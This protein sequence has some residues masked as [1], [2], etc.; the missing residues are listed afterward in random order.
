MLETSFTI[1]LFL[2]SGTSD[3]PL[4]HAHGEMWKFQV[5]VV[6][7]FFNSTDSPHT[8]DPSQIIL[9]R[10][11]VTDAWLHQKLQ[12]MLLCNRGKKAWSLKGRT[13]LLDREVVKIYMFCSTESP[14]TNIYFGYTSGRN[15]ETVLFL[16]KAN[17]SFLRRRLAS[18][19]F[20][21]APWKGCGASRGWYIIL[22]GRW[23][24]QP[25]SCDVLWPSDSQSTLQK[26]NE[27]DNYDALWEYDGYKL[28]CPQG[29]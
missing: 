22:L 11:Q 13:Y 3:L 20:D 17:V 7:F 26:F 25:A 2:C 6:V 1:Y 16:L 10:W 19:W 18:A 21:M 5:V 24:S 29:T 9:P 15:V 8:L 14:D 23:S 4:S 27:R 12:C 28:K